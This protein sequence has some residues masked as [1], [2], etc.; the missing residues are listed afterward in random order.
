VRLSAEIGTL[1]SLSPFIIYLKYLFKEMTHILGN[2]SQFPFVQELVFIFCTKFGF[3]STSFS[4]ISFSFHF[5]WVLVR[6]SAEIGTLAS[7]SPFIIYLKYLFKEHYTFCSTLIS[8]FSREK[9]FI[10]FLS[11]FFGFLCGFQ[12]RLEPESSLSPFI[13]YL[14]Y[15]F[16]EHYTFCT[17]F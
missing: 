11:T 12:P 15:L 6:L 5:L 14:K 17:R 2:Q 1:A 9:T 8:I 4:W 13:I 10:H 7:L 16:K 3:L